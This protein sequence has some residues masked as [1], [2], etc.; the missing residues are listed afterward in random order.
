MKPKVPFPRVFWV[1]IV[2][3]VIERMAFYGVYINLSVY[4]GTTVGLSDKEIGSL[5]GVFALTRSWVPVLTG[6]LSDKLGFRRSLVLSF[7]LY[8][9]AYLSLYGVA[10]LAG[11]SLA[12]ACAWTTV[13]AIA[14]AGAFLKPVIPG[15]VRRYSPADRRTQGFSIFYASVNAGSVVG[16]VLA[17]IVRVLLTLRASIVNS[18]AASLL[19]LGVALAAYFEPSSVAS[20]PS[21]D[22]AA[23]TEEAPAENVGFFRSLLAVVTEPR[24]VGFLVIV[25]G[26]YLLIE[27]FY[28]TFPVY[29]TRMFG[30]KAPREE[31]S[32]INPFAIALF[33]VLVAKL[34]KKLPP[35]PAMAFGIFVGAISMAL[36]GSIPTLL[37]ACGSFF[38]FACAEMIYSPRYYE[39]VSSFAPKGREGLYMGVAL[40]P[41][42]VGGLVG[43]VLSGRLIAAYL[44][45]S[46]GVLRPGV[47]WGTY[48]VIGVVCALLLA[49]FAALFKAPKARE[50]E[51][52]A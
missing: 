43:G 20:E 44:P 45:K 6:A 26:Y 24:L 52:G 23:D 37:G 22:A 51:P 28:Q 39:Y 3:E 14:V 31:I 27:Q 5:L 10:G 12:R 46:G 7:G 17:K 35:V 1:A 15:T 32:L 18:V 11:H 25:S 38:V 49:G 8:A 16:K 9:L 33:Q 34:T 4:L 47:V 50:E 2:L 30:E 41:F 48:A 36:M 21:P 40:V 42:G 13:L 19:G 29:I